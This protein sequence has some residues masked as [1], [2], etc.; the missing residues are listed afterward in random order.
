MKIPPSL[1]FV[2]AYR[3]RQIP[4]FRVFLVQSKVSL[5][6]GRNGNFRM[7]FH[8]PSL[9]PVLN[10]S[11]QMSEFFCNVEKKWIPITKGLVL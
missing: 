5:S 7:R 6:C 3:G 8:T 11:R 2:S 10:R 1:V 4:E 9:L